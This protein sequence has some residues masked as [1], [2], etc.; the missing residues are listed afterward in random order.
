M[1]RTYRLSVTTV[2]DESG[3]PFKSYGV[4][5]RGVCFNDVSVNRNLV[6]QQIKACNRNDLDP[7]QLKDVIYDFLAIY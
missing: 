4:C 2:Y 7:T 3:V 1:C 5:A 6:L